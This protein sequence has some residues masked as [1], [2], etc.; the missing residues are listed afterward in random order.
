MNKR[1]NLC[2]SPRSAVQQ[3]A[4]FKWFSD[5]SGKQRKGKTRLRKQLRCAWGGFVWM[6]KKKP[7]NFFNVSLITK[8]WLP[9]KAHSAQTGEDEINHSYSEIW[10]SCLVLVHK[11]TKLENFSSQ[12]KELEGKKKWRPNTAEPLCKTG[13]FSGRQV[14]PKW[15]PR[16]PTKRTDI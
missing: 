7:P 12:C 11:E 3:P 5:R 15:I 2:L 4:R 1:L 14:F 8:G 9:V 10:D 16:L 6:K 13:T